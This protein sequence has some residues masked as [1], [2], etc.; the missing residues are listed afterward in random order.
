MPEQLSD[1]V[2]VLRNAVAVDACRV[3]IE[4]VHAIPGTGSTSSAFTFGRNFGQLLGVIQTLALVGSM[5]V[6][7]WEQV[8]PQTWQRGLGLPAGLQGPA[9]KRALKELAKAR[10]ASCAKLV[11]LRTCD[12]ML[13]VD[14]MRCRA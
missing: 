1:I 8:P 7:R 5:S 10:F 9:R 11:T 4:K 6:T 3:V 12:A 13:M 2:A 14:W